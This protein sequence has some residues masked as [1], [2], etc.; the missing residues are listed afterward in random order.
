[1]G[2]DDN[3]PINVVKDLGYDIIIAIEISERLIDNPEVFDTVPVMAF[4][5]MYLMTQAKRNEP[6]Y[7]DANLVAIPDLSGYPQLDFKKGG[8]IYEAG[9][10]AV[11]AFRD[12]FIEIRTLIY[13][14]TPL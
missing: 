9:V 2:V 4:Y 6:Y 13:P 8:E 12:A 3:L 1:M 14:D 7:K 11:E 5:Q 10:V